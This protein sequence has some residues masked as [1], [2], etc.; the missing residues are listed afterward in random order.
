MFKFLNKNKSSS[1]SYK[2]NN[3]EIE[4]TASILAYEVART[5]GDVSKLEL[6]VLLTEVEVIAS[7]AGKSKDQVFKIIKE[8]SNTSVSFHEF[9]EDINNEYSKDQKLSLIEFLWKV[10]FA[11]SILETQEEKLIRRIADLIHIKDIE[12]LKLKDKIKKL[13]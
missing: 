4:L 2:K 8:F 11:D 12:V 9:I 10:A 1:F 3:F 13:Y 7:K 5:D 6:D